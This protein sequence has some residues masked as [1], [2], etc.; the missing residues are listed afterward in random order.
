MDAASTLGEMVLMRILESD[1]PS[2]R[3][4]SYLTIGK[5]CKCYLPFAAGG[6]G[7]IG[8]QARVGIVCEALLRRCKMAG[9]L[10]NLLDYT[11]TN[12]DDDAGEEVGVSIQEL[13]ETVEAG[14][15]RREDK[16]REY[17]TRKREA[18]KGKS[19]SKDKDDGEAYRWLKG[20]GDRMKMILKTLS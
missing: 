18:R 17:I 10:D 7:T 13:Y 2:Q 8:D 14:I 15:E 19:S 5:L 1:A 20:S 3:D 4:E 9:M 12:S 11:S 16:G 6:R